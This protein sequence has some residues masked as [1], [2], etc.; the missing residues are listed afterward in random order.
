MKAYPKYKVIIAT[1]DEIP[2]IVFTLECGR[3]GLTLKKSELEKI[4][5]D[6]IEKVQLT[7]DDHTISVFEDEEYEPEDGDEVVLPNG[8]KVVV[9]G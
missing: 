4:A 6:T 5:L 9:E 1:K 7:M 8:E 2:K 3:P